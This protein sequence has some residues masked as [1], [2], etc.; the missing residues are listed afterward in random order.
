MLPNLTCKK[1]TTKECN[2]LYTFVYITTLINHVCHHQLTHNKIFLKKSKYKASIKIF[3]NE[4]AYM[5]ETLSHLTTHD[6]HASYKFLNE[7]TVSKSLQIPPLI[8]ILDR[9]QKISIVHIGENVTHH[10]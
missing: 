5:Y 2:S 10:R 3:L 4:R 8:H 7:R 6:G 9:Q 1:T